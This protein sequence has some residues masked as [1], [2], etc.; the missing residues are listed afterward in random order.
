ME[1]ED[2]AREY[3]PLVSSLC[4]RM[5]RDRET[6]RDAAQEAWTDILRG[7]PG[8]RGESAVSTWIYAVAVRSIRRHAV[9]EK[10][11][12]TRFLAEYFHAKADDGL[13][14][15]RDVPVEDR[16]AWMKEECDACLTGIVHCLGD[17]DRLLY[18][19][20][21]LTPLDWPRIAGAVGASEE[22]CRQRWS[23]SSRKVARFL[24]GHCHLY[25]PDGGCRCKLRAP[26]EKLDRDRDYRRV[27]EMAGRL[28]FL[29]SA[30]AWLGAADWWRS[31]GNPSPA[32]SR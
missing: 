27:R 12:A 8:F 19:L 14:E 23:R 31:A 6:A 5:I 10:V 18:L 16:L 22:A 7:L 24:R 32:F 13:D 1:A 4:R 15:M 2:I 26:M 3:G 21:C 11:Y 30:D 25:N 17:E 20:R 29:R 28:H 9:R